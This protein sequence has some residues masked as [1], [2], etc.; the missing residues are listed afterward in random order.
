MK[1][2]FFL[3]GLLA[4]TIAFCLAMLRCLSPYDVP[5]PPLFP[6]VPDTTLNDTG[7][8]DNGSFSNPIIPGFHPDPSI[9][10]VGRDYYLVNSSFE[11]FPG[12]PVFHSRD[13]VNWRQIGHCLTRTSQLDL[14]R[15]VSNGGIAAPTIRY[16]NGIFYVI[17]TETVKKGNLFVTAE[18]P[19]GPWSDPICV[20]TEGFDPSL[21]FDDDGKVYFQ[22]QEG[23][24][25]ESHIIQY[26]IDLTTG[27]RIGQKKTIWTGDGD[28]WLEGPHLYKINEIYYLTAASGGTGANHHQLIAA[29]NRVFGPYIDYP[30]N[31]I[32][33]HKG[34]T[35]PIQ[36][37]GHADMFE[38]HNGRWWAVFLAGRPMNVGCSP[39][40]R[41]TFLAPVLWKKG[42]PVI[43]NEG[44]VSLTMNGP[45]PEAC[46]WEPLPARD[47]FDSSGL[48]LQYVFLRNPKPGSFSLRER[49]GWLRLHGNAFTI[50]NQDA[51]AFIGRRQ[52]H[53]SAL[54][55]VKMAFSPQQAGEEAGVCIR[56]NESAHYEC[57]VIRRPD[58]DRCMV[59][60]CMNGETHFV[61]SLES[62]GAA[63]YF[64]IE[65]SH[66][67][68]TIS[69]S[70]DTTSPVTLATLETRP[71]TMES[72]QS[73]TGV[74]IGMYA[75]GNGK[76]CTAPADFDW[77]EYIPHD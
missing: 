4:T 69:F 41:E 37:T 25:R 75:T 35:E 47:E 44:K 7:I 48:P 17:V 40:G 6:L 34:T 52:Q 38:D 11:Y 72:V 18:D 27:N 60:T 63:S 36:Y 54:V 67:Q 24:G 39:L 2:P 59:R 15:T 23:E 65:C 33:S 21:F 64:Q 28:Y 9:C 57:A 1:K 43:G 68:Y 53:L 56:L 30:S 20:P 55:R 13:L 58:A 12:I 45:L 76:V 16:D 77:M 10:R 31:P 29:S 42:W 32:L 14:N 66:E 19:A 73:F 5:P 8:V 46:P 49:P 62:P 74:V 71:L 22:S 70:A 50:S 51:C 3:S 61:D 26:R